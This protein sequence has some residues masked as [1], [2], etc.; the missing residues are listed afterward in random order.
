MG[1]EFSGIVA[2]VGR[3]VKDIKVGDYVTGDPRVFCRLCK[4]CKV[5]KSNLCPALSF[6]GEDVPGSFAEYLSIKAEKL[7]V[8]PE[9]VGLLEGCLA[10]PL[11]V[12]LYIAQKGNFSKDVSVG[13]I[14]AG[15]IGLITAALAQK[16]YQVKKVTL[17]DIDESRLELARKIGINEV[18]SQLSASSSVNVVVEAAG[19]G[20]ALAQAL[21]WVEPEGRIVIA[22]IYE[23]NIVFDPNPIVAKELEITGIHGYHFADIEKAL[24][25]LADGKLN[26][27]TLVTIM[28]FEEYR[29]AFSLLLEKNKKV[30]K[31]LIAPGD[32][33]KGN[34]AGYTSC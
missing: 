9:G 7:I 5:G 21:N 11:A 19:S 26:L 22:G 3:E 4:W 12:G 31:I 23:E 27:S 6:I 13:I 15:P 28:P 29:R 25:V 32:I 24:D 10:E 1:H 17:I 33:S 8:L 34:L 30:A 18:S 14:G 20:K 2:E 16:I